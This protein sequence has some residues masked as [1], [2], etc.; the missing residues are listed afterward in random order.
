MLDSISLKEVVTQ[1]EFV[2]T[3]LAFE[4]AKKKRLFLKRFKRDVFGANNGDSRFNDDAEKVKSLD[5]KSS[6]PLFLQLQMFGVDDDWLWYARETAGLNKNLSEWVEAGKLMR[7]LEISKRFLVICNLLV[8]IHASGLLHRNINPNSLYLVG[9]DSAFL[10]DPDVGHFL[11]PEVIGAS[12]KP[13]LLGQ[14]DFLAPEQRSYKDG[15]KLDQRTDLW[16]LAACICFS[17][18]GQTPLE[19]DF[20]RVHKELR[21]IL[22]KAMAEKP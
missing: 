22:E 6:S 16:S 17:I 20:R 18:T 3:W 14:I 10:A 7:P 15:V 19:L 4:R 9:S 8:E 21:E 12:Y 11:D 1:S 2:E 13:S 5:L